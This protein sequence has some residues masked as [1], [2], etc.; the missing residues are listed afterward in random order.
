[1]RGVGLTTPLPP[2]SPRGIGKI[3]RNVEKVRFITSVRIAHR[4]NKIVVV[5]K[6]L[7]SRAFPVDG[8]SRE[9]RELMPERRLA[10]VIELQYKYVYLFKTEKTNQ[11]S[12]LV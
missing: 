12:E 7:P 4:P 2:S 3:K 1:M 10:E 9:A 11:S 5:L 8:N 6:L